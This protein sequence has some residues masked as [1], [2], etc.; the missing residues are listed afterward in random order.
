MKANPFLIAN[1]YQTPIFLC[2]TVLLYTKVDL[3][4][5]P[6]DVATVVKHNFFYIDLYFPCT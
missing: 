3:F 5:L 1:K 2:V 4:Y 6:A